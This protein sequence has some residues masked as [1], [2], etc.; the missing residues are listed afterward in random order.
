MSRYAAERRVAP[1]L[2]VDL[3]RLARAL[4]GVM[5]EALGRNG[6]PRLVIDAALVV[7]TRPLITRLALLRAEVLQVAAAAPEEFQSLA[8]GLVTSG[9]DLVI[10]QRIMYF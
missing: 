9:I 10:K 6:I 7:M 4:F 5:D 1:G 3:G 8:L 2:A